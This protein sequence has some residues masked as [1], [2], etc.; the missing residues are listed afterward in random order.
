MLVERKP[1]SLP[2]PI[3]YSPRP[4]YTTLQNHHSIHLHNHN[5]DPP[6]PPPLPPTPPPGLLR[7]STTPIPDQ[8]AKT[9][10][11]LNANSH[12][13][14]SFA[15]RDNTA[16]AATTITVSAGPGGLVTTASE[17]QQEGFDSDKVFP[18]VD[19]VGNDNEREVGEGEDGIE[20]TEDARVDEEDD[21]QNLS[22]KK[23]SYEEEEQPPTSPIAGAPVGGFGHLFDLATLRNRA[24][25]AR[26]AD[27][28]AKQK[29]PQYDYVYADRDCFERETNEF[30]NYQDNVY[31]QEGRELFEKEFG[32]YE[33]LLIESRLAKAWRSASPEEK[34]S[35]AAFLLDA[36]ELGV[37]DR[38][39]GYAKQL[40]YIAQG[41]FSECGSKEDH[42]SVIKENNKL[43]FGL[44]AVSNYYQALRAVSLALDIV[45]RSGDV[46]SPENQQ[47]QNMT[48]TERQA[49]MDMANAET[50]VYLSL[51]YMLVEVN[52]GQEDLASE[53]TH[54]EP[55]LA[56]YLFA[57]VA[58][59]AEGNRKHYPVKKLLLL[60][61]KVLLATVGGMS[62][63][64]ELK[65]A[66]RVQEGLQ[67]DTPSSNYTKST[68]QDWYQFQISTTHRYPS[69]VVPDIS[70][71]LPSG[72]PAADALLISSH[73]RKLLLSQPAPQ[74]QP[75][76][77]PFDLQ[78]IAFRETMEIYR[79]NMYIS[80]AYVQMARERKATEMGQNGR[81]AD[82][83]G[84][85]RWGDR[86]EK[87]HTGIA[88]I[89]V[90]YDYLLSTMATHI[91][92]L[93]RLLYYVNLGNTAA[94]ANNNTNNGGGPN[95]N[96][97]APGGPGVENNGANGGP[98]NPNGSGNA[99][100]NLSEMNPQQRQEYLDRIDLSRH[101]EVV[102]KA[103]S[104][105][106]LILLKA[107]KCSHV[108]KFEYISQLLVDNNCAILI[109]KMLST[110][111]QNSL[112]NNNG[113]HNGESNGAAPG[114]AAGWLK[115]REDPA[116]L[117]NSES[118][119]RDTADGD[120]AETGKTSSAVGSESSTTTL[121]TTATTASMPSCW[122][123]FFTSINLLRILQKLTKHKTHRV[124]ALVQWKASAV[125]KRIIKVH[126]VGL[127]LFALKLLK[128]QIPYLGR[129]WRSSNMRV[130]TAIY[131]HLRPCLK[132][133]Y[134]SG[135][136]DVDVDDALFQE[137][138]LR[139][140]ITNYHQREHP[141]V[142]MDGMANG[143]VNDDN[144]AHR[145]NHQT[146]ADPLHGGSGAD[147]DEL[148]AMINLSRRTHFDA[149]DPHHARIMALDSG[150]AGMATTAYTESIQL[151]DNFMEN[152]E[153]W[154]QH[155]VYD[156]VYHYPEQQSSYYGYE[157][158]TDEWG[159]P[160]E[161]EASNRGGEGSD[162]LSATQT[163]G[164]TAGA[165]SARTLFSATTSFDKSILS[166]YRDDMDWLGDECV[167]G[168][169]GGGPIGWELP[170]P[171]DDTE[172]WM[173]STF[174]FVD[175]DRPDPRD[176]WGWAAEMGDDDE[177]SY[178]SLQNE[179]EGTTTVTSPPLWGT[180][181][182]GGVVE[183][184]DGAYN[185]AS[186]DGG[187]ESESDSAGDSAYVGSDADDDGKIDGA[188]VHD[189]DIEQEIASSKLHPKVA[190]SSR[191]FEQPVQTAIM[192][193]FDQPH[194]V[195]LNAN[196]K[197]EVTKDGAD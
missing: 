52:L 62:K 100:P 75:F 178:D 155:E 29:A 191:G 82:D 124:L 112:Q 56:V 60:L 177:Y 148:E 30:Y 91:G 12:E 72:V 120:K 61:W 167:G 59:L 98:N 127:Q 84:G 55:P 187:D 157:P 97:H 107:F 142:L 150:A 134:L 172:H 170:P 37:A 128:S 136:Q 66:A 123:N 195:F 53:L 146:R 111:F 35:Y 92:M 45:A 4:V 168:G 34:S 51:L 137:Q 9:N 96:G 93:V 159:P 50:A 190:K 14:A 23:R 58:Q 2:P 71:I 161:P 154:L 22:G 102:T 38:R 48:A 131:M 65:N 143:N 141:R 185:G 27:A 118:P 189:E 87:D 129:K 19:D 41:V 164:E 176:R 10:G 15:K 88:R 103:V 163:G 162:A 43:L 115:A 69:Y 7:I 1:L 122:R 116:E 174:E 121:P 186:S 130:I 145:N 114:M 166:N 184:T 49:A 194:G 63:L 78:P 76:N 196:E 89:A 3:I 175:D 169:V 156:S 47:N 173:P 152:Y 39:Y 6:L 74:I 105:I 117:N 193:T 8:N 99:P 153:L 16:G 106:L 132:E 26:S 80:L 183:D 109:L 158:P 86:Q 188:I 144:Q 108:C 147:H 180:D 104:A 64:H 151:D 94:T 181:G 192:E 119:K 138:Q 140:L 85:R 20:A 33:P 133:D 17:P 70:E 139:S 18:T 165:G 40:L 31:I 54:S 68:P 25:A 21:D 77:D 79:R 42:I 24:A 101:K 126:H 83:G 179:V 5:Q 81:W 95:G 28:L 113:W 160:L 125:L 13:D 197:S 57:L 44:G 11:H 110:W 36:L 149:A 46:G 182:G 32:K 171:A 135:D 67:P 73:T 90:L